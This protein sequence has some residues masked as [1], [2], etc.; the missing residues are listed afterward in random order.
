VR[1][2]DEV[3]L[4][5]FAAFA[6][7]AAAWPGCAVLLCGLGQSLHAAVGRAVVG[8]LLPAYADRATALI[9]AGLLPA[10]YRFDERL[11]PGPPAVVDARHMVADACRVWELPLVVRDAELVV[12]ELV[13]NAIRHGVG[14]VYL[15]VSRRRHF[16]HAAVHDANPALP[17]RREPDPDRESGRGLVI[18]DAVTAGWGSTPA[19]PGKIVWATIRLRDIPRS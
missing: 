2:H 1:I 7:T 17:R 5:V 6:R 12:T 19:D 18:L 14:D 9:A 13:S 4:T 3:M 8:R 15:S 11:R 16:L 10:P